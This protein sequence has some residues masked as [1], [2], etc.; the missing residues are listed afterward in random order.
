MYRQV[1]AGAGAGMCQIVITTPMACK[2]NF[3]ISIFTH[4]FFLGIIENITSR[5]W[6]NKSQICFNHDMWGG[7]YIFDYL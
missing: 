2:I 6:K 3:L 1:A 7:G 4:L 5:F